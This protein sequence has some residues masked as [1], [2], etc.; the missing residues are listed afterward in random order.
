MRRKP[1][2]DIYNESGP[3]LVGRAADNLIPRGL[4]RTALLTSLLSPV[5]NWPDAFFVKKIASLI[6]RPDRRFLPFTSFRSFSGPSLKLR[7]FFPD[8]T[9]KA[10]H[11]ALTCTLATAWEHPQ[12]IASA[13]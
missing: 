2:S 5:F 4:D 3:A 9:T 7:Q 13:P 10:L 8:L 1:E 11:F 6:F 12:P